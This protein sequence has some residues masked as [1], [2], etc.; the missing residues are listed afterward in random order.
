[1]NNLLEKYGTPTGNTVK[2]QE[3]KA[4][5][6]ALESFIKKKPKIK[7]FKKLKKVF[8]SNVKNEYILQFKNTPIGKIELLPSKNKV[9]FYPVKNGK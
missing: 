1:M 2:A 3:Q 6:K 9:N 4:I 5:Y 7:H 8:R